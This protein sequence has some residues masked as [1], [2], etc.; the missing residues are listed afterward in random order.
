LDIEPTSPEKIK[1]QIPTV[2]VEKNIMH[3]DSRKMELKNFL[4]NIDKRLTPLSNLEHLKD[5]SDI[6]EWISEKV[7]RRYQSV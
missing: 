1:E 4:E 2:T 3:F 7:K 6:C 5:V